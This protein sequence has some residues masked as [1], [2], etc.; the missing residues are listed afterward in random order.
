MG[1]RGR[2]KVLVVGAGYDVY[3]R[4]RVMVI[5][6]NFRGQVL[7]NRVKD[8]NEQTYVLRRLRK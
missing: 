8:L 1:L 6:L 4:R 2:V 5:G 7:G 3:E